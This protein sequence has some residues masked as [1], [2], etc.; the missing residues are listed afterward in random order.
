M[1]T[2]LN[3]RD[4]V[5]EAKMSKTEWVYAAKRTLTEF[6][7]AGGTDLAAQ[8]TYFIVLAVAPT[9]LA[10][11]SLAALV[12]SGFQDEIVKVITDAVKNSNIA[13]GSTDLTGAIESTLKSLLGSTSS[14]T[15]ALIIG[16]LTA[17]WSASAFVKAFSRA[18]NKI[19]RVEETRGPVKLNLS[20]LAVTAA[21]IVGI[22]LLFVSMM[23]SQSM[24]DS[25]LGP[26]F[27][28]INMSGLLDFL[29]NTF[30]P[31]WAWVK[32]PFMLALLF[33]V[34]SLLYWATPNLKH[35][36]RFISPGGVFAIIGI[37]LALLALSVY[38]STLASYS[39]YGAIGGVMAVLF[40]LWVVSIVLILGAAFDAEVLRG[41][42]LAAGMPAEDGFELPSRG[43]EPP[44]KADLKYAKI[45]DEGRE[46][47]VGN[48]YKNQDNYTATFAGADALR[49]GDEEVFTVRE[50]DRNSSTPSAVSTEK[51]AEDA[52]D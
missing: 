40:V 46:I 31:I 6:T 48:L 18:S 43:A 7:R 45:V 29:T 10:L 33:A 30:I 47:R 52:R 51:S 36:Y 20:M 49:K 16:I 5:T 32:W 42:Q 27:S 14:G 13:N 25:I 9:F 41:R 8:L 21:L 4:T 22:L 44:T 2:R 24:M 19:Y 3:D 37:A 11:F 50:E 12:L 23:L 34:V 38:M 17:L 28:T 35:K 1:A 39:S 15:I 26:I